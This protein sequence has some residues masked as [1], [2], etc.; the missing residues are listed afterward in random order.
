MLAVTDHGCGMPDSP[1]LSYFENLLSLPEEIDGVRILRG[2]EANVMDLRGTLDIPQ[3]V[4]VWLD[5][6]I[7]SFHEACVKPGTVGEHTQAYLR[8]AENP[9]VYAIGHP[10][11]RAFAFDYERVLP[12]LSANGKA[13]EINA[14]TFICRRAFEESCRR[15]ARL[16][17]LHGLPVLVNSDAH[18]EFDVRSCE[19]ALAMLGDLAFPQSLVINA[20]IDRLNAFLARRVHREDAG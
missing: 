14:H 19:R 12:A 6:V 16:S 11:T 7:A 2:V 1:P 9:Y 13:I 20:D 8:I 10:G 18:S 5:W 3:T 15:I 4:L 17:A